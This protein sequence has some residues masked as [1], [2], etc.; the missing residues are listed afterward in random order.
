VLRLKAGTA[1]L[2]C[3]AK[4][5]EEELALAV[6]VAVVAVVTEETVAANDA[7]EAPA[8]T[9]TLPGTDTEVELLANATVWPPEGAAELSETVHVV[10]PVPVKELLPHDK[11]LT[12]EARAVPVPLTLTDTPGALLD[13]ASCPVTELVLVG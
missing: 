3:I 2:S 12:V 4:L 6:T 13:I 7:V 10:D 9:V 8:P 11:A 5:F 1:A